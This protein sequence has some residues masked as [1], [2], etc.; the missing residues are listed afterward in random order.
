MCQGALWH[1]LDCVFFHHMGLRQFPPRRLMAR[2]YEEPRYEVISTFPGFEV[3]R[4]ADSVQA[5][6]RIEG[7]NMRDST[8]GFR[9][10]AGYI[11]GR[12]DRGQMIAMTAPVHMWDD[13]EGEIMA[14][15]MPSEYLLEDLPTP[16]DKGVKLVNYSGST[17]A[18]L[19]F[20]GLSGPRR[21]GRMK[22]KLSRMVLE[23]GLS[24][25]APPVLAVYDNPTSTLPF[26]RRNEILLPVGNR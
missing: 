22:T 14:F 16:I 1:Y 15:T 5:R 20:S 24:P 13:G 8:G 17:L 2:E 11:F 18:A 26:L 25:N 3:R 23:N 10:I 12:N 6:V 21:S 4:Y 9:R 7:K 19:R